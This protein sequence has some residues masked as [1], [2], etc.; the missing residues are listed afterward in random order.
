MVSGE[1]RRVLPQKRRSE[2]IAIHGSRIP[3]A[4]ANRRR[5]RKKP[6]LE[7]VSSDGEK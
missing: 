2:Q 4:R 1:K 7:G 6:R 3:G 5:R